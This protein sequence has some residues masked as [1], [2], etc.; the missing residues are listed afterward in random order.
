M[1]LPRTLTALLTGLTV[2][3]LS[4]C[5]GSEGGAPGGGKPFDPGIA[6]Q[7]LEL[8]NIFRSEVRHC[9]HLGIFEPA[10]ALS[11]DERLMEAARKHSMYMADTGRFSHDGPAGLETVDKR[12]LAE[13]YTYIVIA[14]NIA[15]GTGMDTDLEAVQAWVASAGHCANL[16]H[17]QI[18]EL[19]IAVVQAGDDSWYWTQVLATERQ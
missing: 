8:V 2:V 3:T 12:A 17:P 16:M 19:G 14:E 4:A 18:R 11:L 1:K 9:G 13:G 6:D 15:W 7:A 10:A 5:G